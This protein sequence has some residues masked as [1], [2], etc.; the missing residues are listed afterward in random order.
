[1]GDAPSLGRRRSGWNLE[2]R[3]YYVNPGGREK[4][5]LAISARR[6]EVPPARDPTTLQV[7]MPGQD[8]LGPKRAAGERSTTGTREA[9]R[10]GEK[11]AR[12]ASPAKRSAKGGL[13]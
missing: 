6:R 7:I 4:E 12:C 9:P 3:V 10:A 11:G 13:N 5:G 1:M 8:D 2:F